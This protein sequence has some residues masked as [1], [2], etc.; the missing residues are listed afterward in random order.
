M[1]EIRR[2]GPKYE[3]THLMTQWVGKSIVGVCVV[4]VL[5][6]G[7]SS[8]RAETNQRLVAER[9]KYF[10]Q[11]RQERDRFFKAHQRS[12]LTPEEKK[13]FHSLHYYPFDPKYIFEGEIELYV[14]DY[15]DP[16]HWATFLTNKGT[17]KRY[18]RY[19]KFHFQMDGK[20][21]AIE[22]YKSLLSDA[23]FIPFK[24]KTNGNETYGGGRYIDAEILTGY[25]MVLDFNTAY[26]PIC[27][28]NEKLVCILPPKENMFDIEVQAGERSEH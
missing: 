23:L 17:N 3:L 2:I 1:E 27:A 24:D 10:A 11:W 15:N 12:P 25:R 13:K 7:F 20:D 22:V 5:S 26:F 6:G 8:L 21:L 9:E 18:V 28:Y 4:L 14:F 16:K 19:G